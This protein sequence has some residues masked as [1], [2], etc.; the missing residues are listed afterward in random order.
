MFVIVAPRPERPRERHES[1][2]YTAA[3]VV[4]T[5]LATRW[6]ALGRCPWRRLSRCPLARKTKR[7]RRGALHL[8]VSGSSSRR[9]HAFPP[10]GAS[11]FGFLLRRSPLDEEK[12][13]R[14]GEA[15]SH[16]GDRDWS[17][18]KSR[19]R[20]ARDDDRRVADSFVDEP[21]P[22][23]RTRLRC[24]HTPTVLTSPRCSLPQDKGDDRPG[25][26][27]RRARR[28][29][30]TRFRRCRRP[31]VP[32]LLKRRRLPLGQR[33]HRHLWPHRRPRVACGR[34]REAKRH[35]SHFV[36]VR[37]V[38]RAAGLGPHSRL[39]SSCIVCSQ[40]HRVFSLLHRVFSVASAA[41]L[42]G[43][44]PSLFSVTWLP[45]RDPPATEP[46]EAVAWAISL[47]VAA[48]RGPRRPR[49]QRRRDAPLRQ[50]SPPVTGTRPRR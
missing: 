45:R 12:P 4:A 25:F 19:A 22:A 37:P 29:T 5:A 20:H 50:A 14:D 30:W 39:G 2:L 43:G 38:L 8:A 16:S 31:M 7:S 47:V 26:A 40:M 10:P 1:S 48:E 15:S 42:C 34:V 33:G 3:A 6:V 28:L 17:L 44:A 23:P 18:S 32:A 27:Q 36:A 41:A 46:H 49:P 21:S 35:T 11:V 9:L 13:R 24:W